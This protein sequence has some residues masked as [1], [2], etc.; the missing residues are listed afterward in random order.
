MGKLIK[1]LFFA[2]IFFGI[3]GNI[4]TDETDD[5]KTKTSN[6]STTTTKSINREGRAKLMAQYNDPGYVESSFPQDVSFWIRIKSPPTGQAAEI[7]AQVVCKQAKN[8]YNTSGFT[9]TIW[10][11]LDNKQYGKAR[12]Y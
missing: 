1:Y 6:A 7:Y 9:I 11:L 10:G 8:D 12:C 3:I 2:I 5:N 4:I